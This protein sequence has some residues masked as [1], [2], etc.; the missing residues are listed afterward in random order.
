MKPIYD[1]L[2][3]SYDL[4]RNA[5][6]NS[7]KE[8]REVINLYN[9][10]Q[11][12]QEQINVLNERGQP[13]E[14]FNV[15]KLMT[16][17][18]L[19]FF[20]TVANDIQIQPLHQS[21]TYNSGLL[22][23]VVMYV[24]DRNKFDKISLKLKMDMMWVGYSVLYERVT[25]SGQTDE[26]GRKIYNIGLEYVPALQV[27]LDPMSKAEDY[28]DARFI[29]RYVW[30]SEDACKRMWPRKWKELIDRYN[31]LDDEEADYDRENPLDE[32]GSRTQWKNY[33]IIHSV[34]RDGDTYWE[35]VWSGETIL[36]KKKVSYRKV[37][38]PYR[39]SKVNNSDTVEHYG[40][41]REV[42]ESQKAINQAIIQIQLLVN[43][44]KAFVETGAVDDID[45]FKA[46]FTR[47]NAVIPMND[48]N[49]V[50]VENMSQDVISQ[51]TIIDKALERIKQVLGVNDSFLGQAYAS[52]S[53]RK[54]QI[55]KQASF[56]QL[57]WFVSRIEQMYEQIGWDIVHL[58]QQYYTAHQSLMI[59]D[60]VN[61]MKY[62]EVNKPAMQPTGQI[63]PQ[64]GEPVMQPVFDEVLNP[65]TGEPE[66]DEYGAIILAPINEFESDLA[67]ADVDIKV[68][69]V[70]YNNAEERN[71]LLFETFLQGPVGQY[72][73]QMDPVSYLQ[74][75]KLMIS[76][77]GTKHSPQ[78]AGIIDELINKV[79]QG[80]VNPMLAMTGGDMQA[81]LGAANGG[82]TGNTNNG[83][84][85][86]MLQIPTSKGEV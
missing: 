7:R 13:V 67:F 41:F 86:Q 26:F 5:Y 34:V 81:I 36:E 68:E 51:Y 22:N 30:L 9:D 39:I 10:R 38:F 3:S 57:T 71:Q 85:S 54:V 56:A 21:I 17:A 64:T 52:D 23:D 31:H 58:I 12:T 78:I 60:P 8:A 19:G 47:V 14:S 84:S 80:Q 25:E 43:T 18:L 45:E 63:D 61:G 83:P 77:Y 74:V 82:A 62:A 75:A 76:E 15:V 49:G 42:V 65:E 53:G 59:A 73:G 55:Q 37:K 29:H 33:Q 24:Q 70:N 6:A 20:G 46:L 4:A 35:V 11:Y 1:D 72:V 40:L 66:K 2:R 32:Q 27:V 28:S 50:R 16:H 48:I 69:S 44:S 79:S